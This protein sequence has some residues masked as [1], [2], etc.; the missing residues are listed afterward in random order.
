MTWSSRYVAGAGAAA[1]AAARPSSAARAC[2]LHSAD[3]GGCAAGSADPS[4]ATT[5][6]VD[7]ASVGSLPVGDAGATT[8][9]ETSH[10]FAQDEWPPSSGCSGSGLSSGT[11]SATTG[12]FAFAGAAGSHAQ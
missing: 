2:A 12:S 11:H 5:V 4:E 9:F 8:D 6:G 3:A 10:G 7:D 1:G